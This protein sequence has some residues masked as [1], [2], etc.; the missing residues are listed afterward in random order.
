M[1]LYF[2]CRVKYD[3][4]QERGTS[5]KKVTEAFL[6]DAVTFGE[7]EARIIA[8]R[9]P[10]ISG[11]FTVKVAKKTMHSGLFLSDEGDKYYNVKYAITTLDE[12]PAALGKPPVEKKVNI[13]VL[14]QAS[15]VEDAL[16]LFTQRMKGSL[17]DYEIVSIIETPY[18]DVYQ[19]SAK[20]DS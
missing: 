6:L 5:V 10:Y 12:K 1:P 17:A 18:L 13:L 9:Q 20:A 15:S 14:V 19:Y 3:K 4:L 11:D 2:E 8:E 7:A 16:R